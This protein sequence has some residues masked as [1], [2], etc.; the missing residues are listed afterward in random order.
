M[1]FRKV[2]VF[3]P[4]ISPKIILEALGVLY[5]ELLSS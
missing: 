3:D 4:S 2:A 5:K 1:H